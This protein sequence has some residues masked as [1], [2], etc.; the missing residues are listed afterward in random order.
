MH[1]SR[2]V[3]NFCYS[4]RLHPQ[5]QF[6]AQ[7]HRQRLHC[8]NT[9]VSINGA[10]TELAGPDEAS[11]ACKPPCCHA[12]SLLHNILSLLQ[13]DLY[14]EFELLFPQRLTQQQKMLLAAGLYLPAK[15]DTAASKALRDFEAAYKDA[16]HGWS[17][18]VL[19]DSAAAE[20]Q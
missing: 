12:S 19:K 9:W 13:G 6:T 15:P 1:S 20:G 14:L 11:T 7:R 17:S 5:L 16:K 3:Q 2:S 10:E 4:P 18:G 8:F